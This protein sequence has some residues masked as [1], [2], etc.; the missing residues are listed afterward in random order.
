M[1]LIHLRV[2]DNYVELLKAGLSKA[3]AKMIAI[4]LRMKVILSVAVS[5]T[6]VHIDL[7]ED[8]SEKKYVFNFVA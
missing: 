7:Y 5:D 3:V 4:K 2:N 6:G 8:G 1:K